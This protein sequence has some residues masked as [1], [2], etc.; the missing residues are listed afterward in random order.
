MKRVYH[1]LF[2]REERH[3]IIYQNLEVVRKIGEKIPQIIV[4]CSSVIPDL[5]HILKYYYRLRGTSPLPES[6]KQAIYIICNGIST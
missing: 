6:P 1:V 2:T 4:I 5:L 3:F